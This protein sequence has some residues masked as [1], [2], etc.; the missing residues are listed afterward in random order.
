[1]LRRLIQLFCVA[2]LVVV[3]D[4]CGKK[5]QQ[6]IQQAKL[7]RDGSDIV[8]TPLAT[9]AKTTGGMTVD[10]YEVAIP[11]VKS[12]TILLV[13]GGGKLDT[14]DPTAWL[15]DGQ[16][17]FFDPYAMQNLVLVIKKGAPLGRALPI[18]PADAKAKCM[19][20]GTIDLPIEAGLKP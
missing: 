12:S 3:V 1:M 4:G 13:V 11:I 16:P 15:L 19:A 14:K 20:G 17:S 18:K 10:A 5:Q 6:G 2:L 8:L 7:K 9:A